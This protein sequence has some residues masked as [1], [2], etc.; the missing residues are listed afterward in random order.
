MWTPSQGIRRE[1]ALSREEIEKASEANYADVSTEGQAELLTLSTALGNAADAYHRSSR[2]H[3]TQ[4]ASA[5]QAADRAQL[6]THR[7]R[8]SA[9]MT[10]PQLTLTWPSFTE[11]VDGDARAPLAEEIGL[12][13]LHLLSRLAHLRNTVSTVFLVSFPV[14]TPEFN[15]I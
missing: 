11:A 5:L 9:L 8:A 12:G 6:L 7:G 13:D 3:L 10:G 15:L 14:F 2:R 4:D 1:F